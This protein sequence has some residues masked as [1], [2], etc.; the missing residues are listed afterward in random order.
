MSKQA[1]KQVRSVLKKEKPN[2][3]KRIIVGIG[4]SSGSKKEIVD[5]IGIWFEK[6]DSRWNRNLVR[7]RD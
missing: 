3:G 2:F 7:K 6:G 4:I 1:S 5:G